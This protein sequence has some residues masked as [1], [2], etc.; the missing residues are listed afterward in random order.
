M[1]NIKKLI[2]KGDYVYALV[3]EHPSATKK[4]YVLLHRIVVENNLGRLLNNNEVVHH[5]NQNKFDNRIENL[6]VFSLSEHTRLH[7][8][9]HG[10][11]WAKLK[12]PICGKI[13]EMP[14][15]NTCYQKFPNDNTKA[16]C[17]CRS[18]G[19]KLGRLKQLHRITHKM[20]TVI[21]ENLLAVYTKYSVDNSEETLD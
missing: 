17:C 6:E 9:K 5:K 12:C 10:R 21:S 14:F 4:G 8:Q 2:K 19:C 11:K 7:M 20:E 13:F 3:P 15:S 1:W 18:C 16:Q